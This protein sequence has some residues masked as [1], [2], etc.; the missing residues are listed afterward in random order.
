[1]LYV[2]FVAGI[3]VA[4][5]LS[6]RV[7]LLGLSFTFLFFARESLVAWWRARRRQREAQNARRL[8]VVYLW[9]SVLFGAPLLIYSHLFGLVPVGVF[10]LFL[11]AINTEQAGRLED[12][13]VLGETLAIIGLT[14]TAPAAHYVA[15]GSWEMTALWLWIVNILYF[16]S[17]V[18]YVRLRVVAANPRKEQ[19]H[20]Q[21]RRSCAYYHS[22]LLASLL[23]LATT[24]SLNLFA[25][26]AF[27]PVIG[28]AFWHLVNPPTQLNLWRIGMFEIAYSAV[29]LI[30]IALA[31]SRS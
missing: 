8:M 6:W 12:R 26:I 30:F 16:T 28:R 11:L 21:M 29:F 9:L 1:M 7:W 25:L 31:F 23:V 19:A 22:F 5:S 15:R 14:A 24:R 17:S 27:G 20:E 13:T 4:R 2:P 10:A 18:F 3:L